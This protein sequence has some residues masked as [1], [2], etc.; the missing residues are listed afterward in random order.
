MRL[1]RSALLVNKALRVNQE[2]M[3]RLALEVH[4]V[5]KVRLAIWVQLARRDLKGMTAQGALKVQRVPL[6]QRV[7]A[8]QLER[9]GRP[10]R[11][12]SVVP[13]VSRGQ[14]AKR[15]PPEPLDR[16]GREEKSDLRAPKEYKVPVACPEWTAKEV[17]K[18][19]LVREGLKGPLDPLE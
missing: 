6:V 7:H 12:V 18:V 17:R 11:P 16:K 9:W 5:P 1:A 13:W 14:R 15:V 3:G 8:V 10:V 4:K 19:L 2:S